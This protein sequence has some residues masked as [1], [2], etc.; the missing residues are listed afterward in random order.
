[1]A[2]RHDSKV[3]RVAPHGIAF[4]EELARHLPIGFAV[5]MEGDWLQVIGPDGPLG[6]TTGVWLAADMLLEEEVVDGAI[7]SLNLVQQEVAEETT[8]PWP[9]ASGRGYLGFPEPGGEL[10]EDDL[11]LW[12]GPEEAPALRLRPISLRGVLLPD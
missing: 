5:E 9:A 6:A 10:V 2:D 8:E 7:A 11:H 12:F 3:P 4:L 1:M